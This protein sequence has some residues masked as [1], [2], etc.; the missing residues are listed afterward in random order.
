MGK[1]SIR[2]QKG[3][4]NFSSAHFITYEGTRCE[5][6]H[7]HNFTTSL[8]LDGTL[9]EN[10]YV[11]DF[12][13]TKKMLKKICDAIDHKVLLPTDSA[14]IQVEQRGDAITADYDGRFYRFPAEDVVLLPIPNV[15]SEMLARYICGEMKTALKAIGADNLSHIAVEVCESP[16]QGA[17]YTEEF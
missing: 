7:G 12:V 10:D 15:T 14:K 9:D 6:L 8:Q 16:G 4:I 11:L 17:T 1:F 3:Y 5:A 2:V 13:K